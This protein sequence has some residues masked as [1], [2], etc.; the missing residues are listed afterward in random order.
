MKTT[1]THIR[2]KH[3]SALILALSCAASVTAQYCSPA[4]SSGCFNW[5]NQSV[6][7]GDIYFVFDGADCYDS[8]QTAMSTT[9]DPGQA[10][11]MEVINGVWCGCAVWVDLDNNGTFEDGE[12][13]H[14]EYVGADPS[15]TY[16]FN[17]TI[18]Q[19]TPAGPHRMRVIAPWGSDGFLTTNV[20]GY[21]PCGDYQYGNF[22]DFTVVVE[23]VD[24]IGDNASDAQAQVLAMPNPGSTST[25]LTTSDGARILSVD[26]IST[27]GRS[28]ATTTAGTPDSRVPI[29]LSALTSGV[30]TARCRTKEGLRLLRLVKE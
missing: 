15:Y 26:L 4:F 8:D 5:N 22:N 28:V 25:M 27:D 30:Y 21:G 9:V 1:S 17:I 12:N 24:G 18:P 7:I 3:L 14:Y 23:G 20:N 11:P 2:M 6:A 16:S 29:D 13:L 19:G 10:I